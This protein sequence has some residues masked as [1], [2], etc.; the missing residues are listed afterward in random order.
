MQLRYGAVY[1]SLGSMIISRYRDDKG[2][3][4]EEAFNSLRPTS[5][6]RITRERRVEVIFL[7]SSRTA[8]ENNVRVGQ[9]MVL[10]PPRP[11]VS[12]TGTT[13]VLSFYS[14]ERQ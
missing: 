2:D 8:D 10:L 14:I 5:S 7:S 13:R 12:D 4:T 9:E 1:R 11:G 6:A 3:E